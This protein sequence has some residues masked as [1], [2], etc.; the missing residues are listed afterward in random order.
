MSVCAADLCGYLACAVEACVQGSIRIIA[1]HREGAIATVV[2]VSRYYNFA[3]N[4]NCHA[5][6]TVTAADLRGYLARAVEARVQASIRIVARHREG[7]VAAVF[8]PSSYDNLAVTLH[9]HARCMSVCAANLRGYP[10][11]AVEV[12][13]QASV[14]VVAQNRQAATVIGRSR[15]DNLTVTLNCHAKRGAVGCGSL[16]GAIE[17]RVQ[18]SICVV[19]HHLE[20][21]AAAVVVVGPSRYHNFPVALNCNAL[22]A[23]VDTA[24]GC[25]HCTSTV[26]GR[27]Q[28][29][30]RVVAHHRSATAA[31]VVIPH[32]N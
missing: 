5:P 29:S 1:R 30:V 23:G 8:G 32:Y 17:A 19:A 26:E 7:G 13:V 31:I 28:A 27:V 25:C 22:G 10:A 3:V 18:A 11:R 2:G 15:Y 9:C 14:R 16:A 20:C 21:R 24:A 4:L 6:Y 12:R